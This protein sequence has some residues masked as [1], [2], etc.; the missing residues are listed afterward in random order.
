MGENMSDIESKRLARRK[1]LKGAALVAGL[2]A[3]PV[4]AEAAGTV[5][6]A[7]MKYQ[8]HPKGDQECSN[9][10]QFVPGKTPQAMGACNVVAG[11]I[12]P[13]GWCVAYVKKT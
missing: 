5:S 12:S 7:A 1:V 3:V 8:D 13:K 11:P 2:A 9:C 6:K 4:L 10:L